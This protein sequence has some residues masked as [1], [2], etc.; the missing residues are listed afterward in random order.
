MDFYL[1][2]KAVIVGLVE[3]ATEFIPVSSTGHILLVQN[4]LDMTGEK[5]YA[6]GIFIQLGAI[7]AVVWLYRQKILDVLRTWRDPKS[8]RLMINLVIASIP[9][10]VI[11]L[12]TNDWVEANLSG[13]LTIASALVVGGIAI[14]LVERYFRRPTIDSVDDIPYSKALWVGFFQ[15]LAMLWPGI[16][17]S[18]ATIMGGLGLGLSRT[19]ATEF[20]FFLAIPAMVG[21]SLI[22]MSD[23]MDV[24]TAADVPVFA[25]GFIVAFISA[26]VVIRALLSYV[27]RNDF[28]P[29]AWYRIVVGIVLLAWYWNG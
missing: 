15:V 11:G 29:F 8:R 12:P 6:F 16:S 28:K 26:L 24:A 18:G 3:G 27:S 9:A 20:S 7:L 13:P 23:I 2:L 4:W 25:T 5:W 19:A 10:A 14:L 1:F 17:R 22:K 21:A